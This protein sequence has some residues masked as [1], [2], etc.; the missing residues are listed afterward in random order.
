MVRSIGQI[1]FLA[2]WTTLAHQES[3]DASD[4]QRI[5]QLLR[6]VL[7]TIAPYGGF[8]S[9]L[10]PGCVGRP[11]ADRVHLWPANSKPSLFEYSLHDHLKI[12]NNAIIIKT[13]TTIYHHLSSNNFI[14]Q[15]TV[16]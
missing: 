4:L 7:R 8:E 10:R 6:R 3:V 11:D 16:I 1:R 13:T 12:I 9:V 14:N 5:L 15:Y 2:Q